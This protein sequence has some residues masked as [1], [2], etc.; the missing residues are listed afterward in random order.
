MIN[1]EFARAATVSELC[2]PVLALVADDLP[3]HVSP[4]AATTHWDGTR[5]HRH[6][7]IATLATGLNR[8]S[9]PDPGLT[10]RASA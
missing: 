2:T 1:T 8:A 7:A 4:T 3:T 9:P 5:L 6:Y 10:D